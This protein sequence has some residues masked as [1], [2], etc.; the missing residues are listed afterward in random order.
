MMKSSVN[1]KAWGIFSES[2]KSPCWS[3]VCCVHGSASNKRDIY[4]SRKFP[5]SDNILQ[6]WM[7]LKLNKG[8]KEEMRNHLREADAS[9]HDENVGE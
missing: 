1:K 6:W 5:S 4:W 2:R 3:F 9:D 7:N 8:K